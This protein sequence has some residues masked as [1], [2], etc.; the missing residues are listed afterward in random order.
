MIAAASGSADAVK[1]LLDH[2]AE[3]NAKESRSRADRADVRRRAQSRGCGEASRAARRRGQ[4]SP[5]KSSQAGA[6]SLRSGWQRRRNARRWRSRRPWRPRW[7]WRPGWTRRRAALLS[8]KAETAAE[9]DAR[10]EAADAAAAAEAAKAAR[11]A[12]VSDLDLLSR[13]FGLEGR[14]VPASPSPRQSPAM[15]LRA[16]PAASAPKSWAA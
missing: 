6:R 7:S 11:D 2:G 1:V 13:A 3:V 12:A 4:S 8:A 16:L 10:D 14:R 9:A 15:S 5:A